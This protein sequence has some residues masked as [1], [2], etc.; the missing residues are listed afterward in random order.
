MFYGDTSFLRGVLEVSVRPVL[1]ALMLSSSLAYS[2]PKHAPLPDAVYE[3][4]TVFIVN[5]SG[6][7]S[8]ADGAFE[9]LTKW[10]ALSVVSDKSKADLIMTF[11][12][13]GDELVK[14]TTSWG[15]FIMT[16]QLRGTDDAVFQAN[17]GGG[18]FHV[19]SNRGGFAAKDCVNQFR[20]RFAEPH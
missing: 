3:A 2:A 5:Q 13:G 19:P 9:A 8:T 16:V 14:G 18:G 15:S 10:G 7:Q 12:Y 4:K 6:F 1:L 11:S 20:K 17:S